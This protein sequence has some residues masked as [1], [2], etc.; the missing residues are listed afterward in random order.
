MATPT[1]P[2]KPEPA[3][4]PPERE[5]TP[6]EFLRLITGE[7]ATP[8][9]IQTMG[10]AWNIGERDI[11]AVQGLPDTTDPDEHLKR[12]I[13]IAIAAATVEAAINKRGTVTT[14]PILTATPE[15]LIAWTE[16]YE[17]NLT[18]N[19]QEQINVNNKLA[20]LAGHDQQGT[21]EWLELRDELLELREVFDRQAG[22]L[23][24]TREMSGL[25][26][27]LAA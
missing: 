13:R 16:N 25:N 21:Q 4:P 8:E 9:Q 23:W 7:D 5:A 15:Q 3:L 10:R 17:Q 18:A 11:Q 12:E 6:E 22:F 24:E 20:K 14:G 19:Y 26:K 27:V 1:L 2:T